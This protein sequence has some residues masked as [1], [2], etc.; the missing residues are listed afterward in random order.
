MGGV[1]HEYET[2]LKV[3]PAPQ[4]VINYYRNGDLFIGDN[5]K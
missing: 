3:T 4:I 5:F 1:V 2:E